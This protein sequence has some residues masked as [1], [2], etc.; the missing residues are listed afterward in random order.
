MT[1][2][3]E[4]GLAH[5]FFVTGATGKVGSRF[6][7]PLLE[8]GHHVKLLVRDAAKADVPDLQGAEIV[9][10]DLV[11]PDSYA[12]AWSGMEVEEA[13]IARGTPTLC[14]AQGRSGHRVRATS[15]LV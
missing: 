3:N 11:Q 10:G 4:G 15:R 1:D 6:A 5:K 14:S 9:E 7:P 13:R 2:S 8:R 12:A